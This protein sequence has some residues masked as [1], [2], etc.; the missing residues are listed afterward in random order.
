MARAEIDLTVTTVSASGRMSGLSGASVTVYARN[1]DGTN[2]SLATVY[3]TPNLG[4]TA[5]N[6]ITSD[7]AGRIN[8]WL[9]Q[10]RQP[11]RY[12]NRYLHLYA[13]LGG[14][15]WLRYHRGYRGNW[16]N[17]AC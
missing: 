5:A 4:T 11:C 13:A 15:A 7:A 2:G 14:Y 8:G 3:T 10:G 16:N 1:T 6:P 12:R 17:A 9:D